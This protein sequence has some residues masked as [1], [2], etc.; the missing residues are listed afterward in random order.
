MIKQATLL[1]MWCNL[2][3]HKIFSP[4]EQEQVAMM[5][6]M[7][8][9]QATMNT[10][11]MT[12]AKSQHP[13]MD[14]CEFFDKYEER[15]SHQISHSED[16]SYDM[17]GKERGWNSLTRK[18]KG[19]HEMV[20]M[21][22]DGKTPKRIRDGKFLFIDEESCIGCTQVRFCHR[23]PCQTIYDANM[24][25]IAFRLFSALKLRRPRSR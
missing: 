17:L 1:L 24:R 14:E 25:L 7:E 6:E 8:Q 19:S 21:A 15:L 5:L 22:S 10:E 13:L 20:E 12:N 3:A 16:N 23:I 18:E 9:L 2:E 4:A 11:L